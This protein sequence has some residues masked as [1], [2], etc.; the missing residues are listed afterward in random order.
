MAGSISSDSKIFLFG[1]NVNGKSSRSFQASYL[2]DS[3]LPS[4]HSSDLNLFHI[5]FLFSA[6]DLEKNQFIDFKENRETI[7]KCCYHYK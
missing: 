2:N 7:L 1:N 4:R 3:F 5:L 6:K